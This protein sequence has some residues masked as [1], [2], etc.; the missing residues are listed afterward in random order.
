[1]SK[2]ATNQALLKAL[3]IDQPL[4]TAVHIHMQPEKLPVVTI[5]RLIDC[6]AML[7]EVSH[8]DLVLREE[9]EPALASAPAL[10]LDA[11]CV[12]A[13]E[14]VAN[15]VAVA[16]GLAIG[17]QLTESKLIRQRLRDA[18]DRYRTEAKLAISWLGLHSAMQAYIQS[19]AA[20]TYPV[21]AIGCLVSPALSEALGK[22]SAHFNS[23]G[24]DF[25]KERQ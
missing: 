15:V 17:Q 16:T 13:R 25:G 3:G 9:A 2:V 7:H 11:M 23:I 14:R 22:P 24:F 6:K 19:V 5:E 12:A 10:D 18:C 1:M 20:G 21:A 4:I 8:F